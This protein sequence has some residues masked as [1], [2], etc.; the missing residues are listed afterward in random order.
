MQQTTMA[1]TT[2]TKLALIACNAATL[3]S[4]WQ[5]EAFSITTSSKCQRGGLPTIPNTQS[6]L[7]PSPFRLHQGLSNDNNQLN[8]QSSTSRTVDASSSSCWNPNLRKTIAA[9]SSLG[10]LETAYLT[11]DKLQYT[12]SGGNSASLVTALCSS[13]QQGSIGS[14]NDVLHGPYAS[15]HIGTL[16]VPLSVLGMMAYT[17]VFSLAIFPVLFNE[18]NDKSISSSAGDDAVVVVNGQNRIALL[19]VTTLMASFSVYLVSL[20]IGVL[21]ASCLFC[22][23]SAGLS[24]SMAGLSWF[25]GMLP[26]SSLNEELYKGMD[27]NVLSDISE[28]RK[29][30]MSV[31]A[32]SVGLATVMALGIF[33]TVDDS[34][35]TM[36]SA[37]SSGTLLASTSKTARF[38]ENAP[39]AITT[40]SSKAALALAADLNSLDARM[41]GA[42][43][44]SHCYDQKQALGYEAMQT[45]PYIECDREG[46]NSKRDFCKEKDLPGYPTWEIGGKLFPGERSVDELREMVD[47]VMSSK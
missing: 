9:I 40:T 13:S 43:W 41:F 33:L 8:D 17:M 29:N 20:I 25:G 47:E 16:D 11:F 46:F 23:L 36:P 14:C 18:S 22:F 24:V 10:I 37:A 12:S 44:C 21:H 4:S 39:P 42:F 5:V 32:S 6:S 1:K 2:I 35:S 28:L 30:G 15:L 26:G 27:G 38:E 3:C 34:T 31:G 7:S 19:G 45:I